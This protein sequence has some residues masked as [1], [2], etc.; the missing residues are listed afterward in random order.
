MQR[1]L[2]DIS[3]TG[4]LRLYAV[5]VSGVTWL[6]C[7]VAVMTKGWHDSRHEF[8]ERTAAQAELVATTISAAVTFEDRK[9]AVEILRGLGVD[10]DVVAT[11][12]HSADG[13]HFA[14]YTRDASESPRYCD[15][16][17]YG[18][19]FT[20]NLLVM[21]R[22]IRLAERDIGRVYVT[23]DLAHL[24]VQTLMQTLV[25]AATMLLAVGLAVIIGSRIGRVISRPVTELCESAASIARTRDYSIRADKFG[26]DELGRLTD[27]FND[28]LGH[29]ERGDA[30]LRRSRRDLEDIVERRTAALRDSEARIRAVI[31]DV[32]AILWEARTEPWQY[33]FVSRRAETL[34]GYPPGVWKLDAD[35][36]RRLIHPDDYERTLRASREAIAQRTEYRIEYRAIRADGGELWVRDVVRVVSQHTGQLAVRG[37]TFDI[38]AHRRAAQQ[39]DE[40]RS[41]AE[42]ANRVK[43][44]FL[45]NMSHEI[46]TPMTAILGFATNLRD[47]GLTEAER[48]DAVDTIRRNGEQL[49]A[50]LN[51]V[52]DLSKVEAGKMSVE[53]CRCS[54]A[55][56]L[57][58]VAGLMRPGAQAKRLTL[59]TSVSADVPEFVRSDPARIRQV[60]TN[61]VGNAIK[62]THRGSVRLDARYVAESSMIAFDVVDTGI[63]IPAAQIPALFQPFQQ[64]DASMTRRF[65]GTGLGLAIS[66]RFAELLGGGV[67]LVAS[68][69]GAGTTFR[70]LLPAR[71]CS[72]EAPAPEPRERRVPAEPADPS[73]AR[74]PM[75]AGLRVLLAE[76]GPDNQKLLRHVLSKA[77]A[78]VTIVE[79]GQLAVDAVTAAEAGGR[80]F[81]AVLMD[82]QMPVMD[83]YLATSLL[84]QRGYAG[85]IVALTAHAMSTDRQK[86]LDAGCDEYATKP[87][88]RRRLIG[89]IRMLVTGGA[90]A[91]DARLAA[92]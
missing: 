33:E 31:E 63:G 4:K 89:L 8:V 32:D 23:Y 45:A 34:L 11:C 7:C 26:N 68:A 48:A 38:T 50:I 83:G 21:V 37:I 87:I 28:M 82:M 84:R 73:A 75:L 5:I 76:D 19:R 18:H 9:G 46:R 49:L 72:G 53:L 39:L 52:L 12:V 15:T 51:D 78:D 40:A 62:F 24:Q 67:D 36:R 90:E 60:L 3:F 79:N 57:E 64:G 88:D 30:A 41:R 55:A 71:P 20:D 61:L 29:I 91:S 92:V 54:P 69:P 6:L 66:R 59:Q 17:E 77:G 2:R 56:I 14:D 58:E 25:M 42:A 35:F 22:P 27:A 86:C 80:S 70:F 1:T 10:R 13:A 47:A 81:H 16:L 74:S 85:P 43:S 65:G 44:E